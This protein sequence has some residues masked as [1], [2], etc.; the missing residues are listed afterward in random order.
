MAGGP[1]LWGGSRPGCTDGQ[2]ETTANAPAHGVSECRTGKRALTTTT[3]GRPNQLH[4]H[5]CDALTCADGHRKASSYGGKGFPARPAWQPPV[6]SQRGRVKPAVP[7][8]CRADR[9]TSPAASTRVRPRGY[10]AVCAIH[11]PGSRP[12]LSRVATPADNA[13]TA[14][15]GPGTMPADAAVV[16][17][18]E[19]RPDH[20]AGRPYFCQTA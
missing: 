14:T 2:R 7:V 5:E 16:S 10:R 18:V 12:T 4:P 9:S 8:V 6:K 19:G 11:P 3:G 17:H 15:P 20:M 13:E 1:V